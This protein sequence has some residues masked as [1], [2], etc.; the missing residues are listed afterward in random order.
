[1]TVLCE[2]V[3]RSAPMGGISETERR[4]LLELVPQIEWYHSIDLG[5]GIVTPGEYD[6][7][8]HLSRYGFPADMRGLKVLDVG[9][10]SGFFSFEFERRGADVLSVELP[11]PFEKDIVGG[12]LVKQ[13]IEG[14]REQRSQVEGDEHGMRRDFHTAHKLLGSRVRSLYRRIYDISQEATNGETFDLAFCGS[15]LNHLANPI[16]ALMAVRSVTR[17]T[18]VVA[19]PY[20][21]ERRQSNPVARLVGRDTRSLT[22]W[23][24]PTIACMDEMLNASGFT[25]VRLIAKNVHL[26]LRSGSTVPHF[27]MHARAETSTERWAE[28]ARTAPIGYRR[29]WPRQVA[30]A[31]AR[32]LR[33]R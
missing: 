26:R 31:I 10:A 14:G 5:D 22:T 11:S 30:G 8:P 9:R 28:I 32:A 3:L 6:H 12:A 4:A 19:N 7:R 33:L 27:V 18:I 29:F 21:P 17:G 24:I 25:G 13:M 20:E 16:A 1:M 2:V 15:I 23:W